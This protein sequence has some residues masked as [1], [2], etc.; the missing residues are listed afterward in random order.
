M[1]QPVRVPKK[2]VPLQKQLLYAAGIALAGLMTGV[3]IKL[4]DLYTTNLGNL[5]S[6]VSVW[7]LIGSVIAAY[8]STP[9]R[10]AVNVFLF[11]AGMLATYYLTA[12]WTGQ[13]YSFA[14]IYG[15]GIFSLFSPVF[16]F[17]TWYAKGK[18]IVS[19]FLCVGILAVM[20]AAAV[21]L[22]D[23][24]RVSDLVIAALTAAVLLT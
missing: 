4:F 22:F 9:K 3:A 19:R 12:E 13:P 18:T 14:F 8:S 17:F 7:I 24:I 21:I 11:C 2:Q 23:G 10:A 5:F 6:Q 15:W 20:L 16:A 1:L